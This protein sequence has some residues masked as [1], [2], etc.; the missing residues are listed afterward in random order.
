MH[1]R[2]YICAIAHICL[3]IYID[4]YIL[5]RYTL[6]TYITCILMDIKYIYYICIFNNS[7]MKNGVRIRTG[8]NGIFIS[9]FH[10]D[11]LRESKLSSSNNWPTVDIL[12]LEE[13]SVVSSLSIA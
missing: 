6:Y 4:I 13:L 2:K 11:V 10:N 8:S 1:V 3:Y 9:R 7:V 12:Y 5:Y